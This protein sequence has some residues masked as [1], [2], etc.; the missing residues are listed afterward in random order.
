MEPTTPLPDICKTRTLDDPIQKV[1]EA[2]ATKD[3]IA[4]WFVPNDFLPRQGHEFHVEMDEPQGRTACKVTTILPPARLAYRVGE[5]WTWSFELKELDGRTELTFRW[6][7]W[8][9]NKA[10]PFGM[11]YPTLHAHLVDGTNVLI[12]RLTRSIRK[13]PAS[14]PSETGEESR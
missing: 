13:L 3:G 2:I 7:G 6:S 1:W 9:P 12:K 10:T 8:D 14:T 4:L 5:D 11:P